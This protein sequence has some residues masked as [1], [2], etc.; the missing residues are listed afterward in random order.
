MAEISDKVT[1]ALEFSNKFIEET[2]IDT[3]LMRDYGILADAVNNEWIGYRLPALIDTQWYFHEG[4]FVKYGDN[5]STIRYERRLSESLQDLIE[6]A[7]Q[8][9]SAQSIARKHGYELNLVR[10]NRNPSLVATIPNA[11]YKK[12]AKTIGLIE[13]ELRPKS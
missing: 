3:T 1:E 12:L 13:A 6:K 7:K 8:I 2:N 5:D 9:L 11:N 10:I 4:I